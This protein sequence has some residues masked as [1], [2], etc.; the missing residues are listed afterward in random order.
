MSQE[1]GAL[2]RKGEEPLQPC[3]AR[4]PSETSNGYNR[5]LSLLIAFL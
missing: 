3:L 1:L 5:C 2:G 4:P